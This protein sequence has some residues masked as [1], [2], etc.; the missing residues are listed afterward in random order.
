MPGWDGIVECS[1]GS[2]FVPAGRSYWELSTKQSGSDGKAR[3]D[4]DKRV[5]ETSPDERTDTT[6]VAVVCAPWTKARRFADEK[7]REGEFGDVRTL[8]ADGIE[9][10]LESA[11]QTTAWLRGQMGNPD[12]ANTRTAQLLKLSRW[13]QERIAVSLKAL[14]LDTD[15]ADDIAAHVLA[16]PP[17]VAPTELVTAITG[18][19][20]VGKTT[21]LLRI[22][23]RAIQR[24]LAESGAPTPVFLHA[25][26]VLGRSL[27]AAVSDHLD[28][29][30]DPC[31]TG[32][33]III[34]G[35]DET[36]LQTANLV[37]DFSA[38]Q[39]AWPGSTVLIG[40]RPRQDMANVPVARVEPLSTEE[41]TSLMA[42]ICPDAPRVKW[43]RDADADALRH[44]LFA[45]LCA[46]ERREDGPYRSTARDLSR[47]VGKRAIADV[48]GATSDAYGL[49]ARIAYRVV[50]SGGRPAVLEYLRLTPAEQALLMDSR[51]IQTTAETATF[52]LAV[53]TEWF[54]AH[55]LLDDLDKLE[56]IASNPLQA[57]RWRYVLVQA[58]SWGSSQQVDRI[59]STLLSR[60]P[61]T[62]AWVCDEAAPPLRGESAEPLS[63]SD[64][65]AA[66]TR[67][68][69]AAAA[70]YGPWRIPDT[71]WSEN[72]CMPTLGYRLPTNGW[73]ETAW[74]RS[75]NG[76]PEQVIPLPSDIGFD[77]PGNS[78]SRWRM[79]GRVPG[80]AWPWHWAR[81]LVQ[82]DIEDCFRDRKL[83]RHIEPCWSELAWDYAHQMLGRSMLHEPTAV[84]REELEKIVAQHRSDYP[85]GDMHFSNWRLSE[86]E[87]FVADLKRLGQD[88]IEPPWPTPDTTG[89][90][91]WEH[92][93]PERLRDRL[94]L[95][96]KAALDAYRGIVDRHLP[97]M[98]PELDV[99]QL[100]PARIVGVLQPADPAQAHT[101]LYGHPSFQW[102]IEPL[103]DGC[104]QNEA[105]WRIVETDS[106]MPTTRW[107]LS[108][109]LDAKVRQVRGAECADRVTLW[110]YGGDAEVYSSTPAGHLALRLLDQDLSKHNWVSNVAPHPWSDGSTRPHYS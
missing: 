51:I 96:T 1:V 85:V 26:E 102:H 91:D 16:I 69:D 13:P 67:L 17:A 90:W 82:D 74:Q 57:H 99:Y 19:M 49:F 108:E 73:V 101:G 109:N 2:Q 48:K 55:A 36:G 34:D 23:S 25:R 105:D 93:T 78:W 54:A 56:G 30:G 37:N 42:R 52:H 11:P 38:L 70:F 44:P 14:G 72:G 50:D 87:A 29:F 75:A 60:A 62:A 41:A 97:S 28:G 24:A 9:A 106:H 43:M 6:Y 53:L 22:H 39:A 103:P 83:L 59:M 47:L 10:W 58:M 68:R 35:L 61:A 77:N 100:L 71:W 107:G 15:E 8:N 66:G 46:L 98:A 12:Q 94:Q 80:E 4:Y 88:K 95:A 76:S 32:V 45:I 21:E 110:L 79:S 86:G 18:D 64:A 5:Q 84:R 81:N 31:T 40:T 3:E 33:H 63:A 27:K 92:W 89:H 65:Q 20:G 104:T 7:K